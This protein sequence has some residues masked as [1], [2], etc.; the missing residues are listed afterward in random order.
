MRKQKRRRKM[1][2][3]GCQQRGGREKGGRRAGKGKDTLDYSK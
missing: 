3:G 2:E 1:V